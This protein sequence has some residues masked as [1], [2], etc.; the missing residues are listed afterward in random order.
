MHR[1]KVA[2]YHEIKFD[3]MFVGSDWKG[4]ELFSQV[5]SELAGYG[6]NVVYFDYTNHVSSTLLKSTLQAI[7]DAEA[8]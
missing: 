2:S 8:L 3:I 7:Y 5:E 4:S 6:V 1:N